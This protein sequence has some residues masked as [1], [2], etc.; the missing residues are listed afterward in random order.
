MAS[1]ASPLSLLSLPFDIRKRI[2]AFAGLIRECPVT[3]APSSQASLFYD[4]R[5]LPPNHTCAFK[6]R[7]QGKPDRASRGHAPDCL[8]PEFPKQLLLVCKAL[9]QEV[10]KVLYGDNKFVLC[11]HGDP[12]GLGALKTLSKDAICSL[13]YLLVRLNSWPCPRGHSRANLKMNRCQICPN[14]VSQSDPE[15]S[16]GDNASELILKEWETICQ[17][18]SHIPPGHLQLEFICDVSDADT[19][20]RVLQALDSIPRLKECIIRLGRKPNHALQSIA[21]ETATRVA[22]KSSISQPFHY[23]GLP[24]EVRLRILWYT[25][26]GLGGSFLPSQ[27]S[28]HVVNGKLDQ[29]FASSGMHTS[30]AVRSCC[31]QCSF[32]K[33]HCSCPLKYAAYSPYCQCRS[34]P[35]ELFHVSRQMAQDASEVLYSMN[36]FRFRGSFSDTKN[37]LSMI[38]GESLKQLKRI[39]FDLDTMQTLHWDKHKADWRDLLSFISTHCDHTRLHLKITVDPGDYEVVRETEEVEEAM[40]DFYA[41]YVDLIRAIKE[42]GLGLQ[43][44]HLFLP[45]FFDLEPVLERY[46]MGPDYDSKNGNRY[47]KAAHSAELYP[48]VHPYFKSIPDWHKDLID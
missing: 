43:D 19:A 27:K 10:Q 2:Y 7:Q 4:P 25:N 12:G 47:S 33:L 40:V 14:S 15:L 23:F 17:S 13:R 22:A 31:L 29:R 24:Q 11:T 9:H 32:T 39:E 38:P 41:A 44:F 8:C 35:L 30:D 45:L 28:L 26:L 20:R 21:T 5:P 36:I 3:I 34:L 46:I 1:S 48:H 42:A 18:L 37:M 6:F 16:A